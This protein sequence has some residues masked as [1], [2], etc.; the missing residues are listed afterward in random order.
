MQNGIAPLFARIRKRG[1]EGIRRRRC[2]RN[3]RP[4]CPVGTDLPFHRRCRSANGGGRKR[5]RRPIHSGC[6]RGTGLQ[7]GGSG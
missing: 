2:T 5:R 6:A 3:V 1:G 4:R 7:P